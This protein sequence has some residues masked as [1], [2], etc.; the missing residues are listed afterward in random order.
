[1]WGATKLGMTMDEMAEIS[2]HAPM[3]GATRDNVNGGQHIFISIHAPMWGATF[4]VGGVTYT[5]KFQS[6]HPCG[7]RLKW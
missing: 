3:W 5:N 6:T 7:V 2:I 4:T 1:M